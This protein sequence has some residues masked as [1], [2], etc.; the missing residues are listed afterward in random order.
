MSDSYANLAVEGC[1]LW[2]E[3]G[4]Q[5]PVPDVGSWLWG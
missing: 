3:P 5:G 2:H 4:E 1:V